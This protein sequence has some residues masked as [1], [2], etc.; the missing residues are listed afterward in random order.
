MQMAIQEIKQMAIQIILCVETNKR[1]DTDII[2]ILAAI[3][4]WYQINNRIKI[5]KIYMNAKSMYN[6]KSVLRQI[7]AATKA[8]S[9]GTTQV[10]YCIDTDQYE[11]NTEHAKELE[12]ISR[13]CRERHYDLIWFCHDV[14]EVFL[15]KKVSDSQKVLEAHSFKRK[16]EIEQIHMDRL[17]C[18]A[19]RAG[20][21]NILSILDRYLPRKEDATERSSP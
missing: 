6:S 5:S 13:Y 19:L 17:S 8:F 15:G 16:E 10:I 7:E 21:S 1:A 11:K 18:T 14:E 20:T 3:K 9:F 4:H 2:Y 12:N